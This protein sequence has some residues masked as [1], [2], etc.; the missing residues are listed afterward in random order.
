MPNPIVHWE[1]MGKDAKKTIEFY[2][3]LFNWQIDANNPHNYGMVDTKAGGINGGVGG[4]EGDQPRV[5]IYAEVDDLQAYLNSA[6][7]LGGK[8]LME[9][10]EIP[11]AVT[12]AMFADPDG[13]T[14][15]LI[16]SGSMQQA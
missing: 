13:N 7:E 15:G 11:G 2:S 6:V 4:Y 10:T 3:K 1:I 8:V 16:K 9:P 14:I 5:S 12:M